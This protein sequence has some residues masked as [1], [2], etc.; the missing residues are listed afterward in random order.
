MEAIGRRREAIS[1]KL[2]DLRRAQNLTQAQV[3]ER[4]GLP[5]SHI[6]RLEAGQHSPSLRTV[7]KLAHAFNVSIGALDPAQQ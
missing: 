3:A 6:S 2:K 4:S 1:T 5:Q 7:E